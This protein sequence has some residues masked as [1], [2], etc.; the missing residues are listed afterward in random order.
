MRK[1]PV[2]H[3]VS[4]DL[5]WL[6]VIMAL[7]SHEQWW[8]MWTVNYKGATLSL[9][10]MW[11]IILHPGQPCLEPRTLWLSDFLTG[12]PQ[13]VRNGNQ[14]L[15]TEMMNTGTS[16]ACK[17]Y[18][19][20]TASPHTRTTPSWNLLTSPQSLVWSLEVT[21][22][23]TGERW[24]VWWYCVTTTTSLSTQIRPRR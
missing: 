9:C 22:R 4:E 14:T 15:N 13:S 3:F 12:K 16:Q 10:K 11:R 7:V 17:H 1:E 20:T 19:P 18:S 24:Q 21:K 6:M 5:T 23:R 2:L 8:V